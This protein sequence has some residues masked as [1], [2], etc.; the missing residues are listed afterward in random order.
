MQK[1]KPMAASLYLGGWSN[2]EETL[3]GGVIKRMKERIKKV[4]NRIFVP[5]FCAVLFF[6]CQV[7]AEGYSLNTSIP[8]EVEVSGKSIPEGVRYQ[9]VLEA[10]TKDAP[11]PEKTVLTIQNGGK[12]EFGP[13]E[14][15]VPED[16]QY[17]I[18]QLDGEAERFTYDKTVYL[19]TVRVVNDGKGGLGSEIWAIKE[20]TEK[21]TDRIR[22]QNSYQAP[23]GS[24][25]GKTP[26][27][28]TSL[29]GPQTGDQMNLLLWTGTTLTSLLLFIL[30]LRKQQKNLKM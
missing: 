2:R 8:V 30:L 1:Q 10:V 27:P 22:F 24:G 21:K 23:G 14:Y 20:G 15:T 17:K 6:P 18:Y 28:S 26:R 9:V 11:M 7:L 16:Y 13:I 5:L 29:P 12:A 4:F 19:V 25:S 3:E